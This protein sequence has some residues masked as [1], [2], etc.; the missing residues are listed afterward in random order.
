MT[1]ETKMMALKKLSAFKVKIGYPDQWRGY[2]SL[3]GKITRDNLYRLASRK[4]FQ[5]Q[6]S[7]LMKAPNPWEWEN[8]PNTV[9]ACIILL[10]RLPP[11]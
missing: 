8:T 10:I 3:N 2:S 5:G 6:W 11:N 1:D 4:E 9:N 7:E